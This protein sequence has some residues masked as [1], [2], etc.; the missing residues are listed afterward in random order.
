MSFASKRKGK[1]ILQHVT[2]RACV[3]WE[4]LGSLA[5]GVI[6][7]LIAAKI[8]ARNLLCKATKLSTNHD[9]VEMRIETKKKALQSMTT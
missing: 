4:A 1:H 6:E 8:Y 5:R 7:Q 3:P 2:I 9:I